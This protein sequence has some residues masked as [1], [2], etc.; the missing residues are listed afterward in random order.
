VVELKVHVSGPGKLILT[1]KGVKADHVK[2]KKA[3]DVWLMVRAK[4]KALKTLKAKGKVKVKVKIAFV[5]TEGAKVS[6]TH[7]LTLIQK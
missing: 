7:G 5:P 1:G 4:G 6:S 2:V 3:G